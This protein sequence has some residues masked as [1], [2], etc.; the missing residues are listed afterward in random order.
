MVFGVDCFQGHLKCNWKFHAHLV[1]CTAASAANLKY[2]QLSRQWRLVRS[3]S[4][5]LSGRTVCPVCQADFRA[6]INWRKTCCLQ[7]YARLLYWWLH[8]CHPSW[9][10]ALG[11]QL[12]VLA[13]V[14]KNTTCQTCMKYW[15]NGLTVSDRLLY[16]T[17]NTLKWRFCFS[18]C[19]L[20]INLL[21]IDLVSML[22]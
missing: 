5:K 7:W 11:H 3:H 9:T 14:Q 17:R 10:I 18:K 21:H 16:V 20:V 6:G 15:C 2:S 13:E 12:I 4:V 8:V 22:V 1:T 19:L